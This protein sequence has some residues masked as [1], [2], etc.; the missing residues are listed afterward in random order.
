M[1]GAGGANMGLAEG[2]LSKSKSTKTVMVVNKTSTTDEQ[3]VTTLNYVSAA[4]VKS[5]FL[6]MPSLCHYNVRKTC[7]QLG[8]LVN[9][10]KLQEQHQVTLTDA[11]TA[12]GL[13]YETCGFTLE[14]L[15][16]Q[17]K[18][19]A[20]VQIKGSA[21][22]LKYQAE[23]ETIVRKLHPDVKAMAWSTFLLRGGPGENGPAAGAVH[24][25]WFPN[26][27]KVH[28][29]LDEHKEGTH[30]LKQTAAQVREREG[31]EDLKLKLVLGLWKPRNRTNP[32]VEAPLVVCHPE[33]VDIAAEAVPQEQLFDVRAEGRKIPVAN[34]AANLRYTD[35][36][37][38]YYYKEQ[39]A[40]EVIVFRHATVDT[41]E[42]ANFHCGGVLP[43]P[44]GMEKRSSVETRVM[45]Y[46]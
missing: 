45:L 5:Q 29:Y 33:S 31:N 11:R 42:F 16:S 9:F 6:G 18:N 13:A 41:P 44:E 20:D 14:P 28:A 19:W 32:V 8:A 39:T 10:G 12:S 23:L 24:L 27:A 40:D 34:L 26:V 2:S 37:R 36:Q 30:D 43:L 46:F 15:H 22:Q 17:V 4:A 1:G 38:W 3:A 21:E 35:R 7:R 25:D